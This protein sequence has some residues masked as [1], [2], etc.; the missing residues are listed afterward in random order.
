MR[1]YRLTNRRDPTDAFSGEGARRVAGRWHPTGVRVIYT[2]SSVALAVVENLVHFEPEDL[3]A[4]AFLYEVDVPDALVET[5]PVSALPADWNRPKRS[6]DAR[7]YGR[8]WASSKRSLALAVPSVAVPQ[9]RNILLNPEHP[10]FAALAVGGPAP[11]V[12]DPRL[13][14][15][16][17]VI[18]KSRRRTRG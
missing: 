11:F 9:E 4:V 8:A 18:R 17:R 14:A 15:P 7:A 16:P 13:S 2:S 12:F 10:A 5:P 1:V 6:D 3:A